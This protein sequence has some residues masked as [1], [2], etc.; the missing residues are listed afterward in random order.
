[1][2]S[3][4]KK[5]R[6]TG[7]KSAQGKAKSSQNAVS[8]GLTSPRVMPDE[9]EMVES[10]TQELTAYYKPESPLEVLQIQRIALCRAKL[11]KLIDIEVAGREIAR[12]QIDLQPEMVMQRLTQYPEKLRSLA[13]ASIM[14]ESALLALGLDEDTL[15]AIVQ[16]INHFAG[17]LEGESDLVTRFPKLCAYLSGIQPVADQIEDMGV[18]QALMIFAE[19]IRNLARNEEPASHAN[20]HKGPREI[21]FEQMMAQL[22]RSMK[23]DEMATRKTLRNKM[24][25]LAG[26]QKAVEPDLREITDLASVLNKVPAVV[27]SF[28]EM[29]GWMMRA[30]DLQSEEADR[31]MKY[32]TMLER[33]LSSAIGELLE[34]RKYRIN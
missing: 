20:G 24:P 14:G 22:H 33:R 16:E 17:I 30:A 8:H 15:S 3:P 28:H 34:L 2:P 26:Y 18:D 19:R 29:K 10:F 25:G 9:V 23:I 6:S 27:Q 12:R 1:M 5:S 31:M 32:Q 13:L 21:R 7:P 11:A 4:A